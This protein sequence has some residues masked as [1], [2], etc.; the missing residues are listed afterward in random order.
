MTH[1]MKDGG[2]VLQVAV[3]EV[4]IDGQVERLAAA[5]R[6]DGLRLR[7]SAGQQTKQGGREPSSRCLPQSVGQRNFHREESTASRAN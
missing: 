3:P 1:T 6:C 5:G 2:Q 4:G 7:S